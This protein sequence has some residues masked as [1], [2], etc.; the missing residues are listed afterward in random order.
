MVVA[1]KRDMHAPLSTTYSGLV[2]TQTSHGR[3]FLSYLG[4]PATASATRLYQLQSTAFD[5]YRKCRNSCSQIALPERHSTFET[6]RLG[7]LETLGFEIPVDWYPDIGPTLLEPTTNV[8]TYKH[9]CCCFGLLHDSGCAPS[10]ISQVP[11]VH[12]MRHRL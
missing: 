3:L 4:Q 7:F 1:F 5:N 6:R 12:C 8:Y 10:A 11:K 9:D 2:G